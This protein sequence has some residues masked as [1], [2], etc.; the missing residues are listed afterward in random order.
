MLK[1]SSFV[2]RI[3]ICLD[4]ILL[5]TVIVATRFSEFQYNFF[6]HSIFVYVLINWLVWFVAA[7]AFGLYDD[8]RMKPISIEW[9]MF[10]KAFG[11]FTLVKSFI[12]FQVLEDFSFER[13]PFL[14]NSLLI[15]ILLPTVKLLI[16]ILFKKLRNSNNYARKVLIVGAG[17]NG[18]NFYENCVANHFYGYQLTGFLDDEKQPQ[19]NGEYLGK[20]EDIENVIANY[21]VDDIVVALPV[22]KEMQIRKIVAVGEREG[23][24]VRIV[25]DYT[26][27][28]GGKMHVDSLGSLSVIT[29]RSLPLDYLD[30]K[31]YKRIFD[32][33]FSV[34]GIVFLF[35]WLFPIIASIIKLTSKGPVLFKQ[36]RWGLNN[37]VI[38]CLK[39]RTMV[40]NC[41][42]VDENGNYL[43]AQKND[44]R[45]TRIGKFLRKTNLDELPQLFNVLFGSMSLVGPRPHPVPLN[46][47]SKD[48]IEKYMMRH[49]VKPGI[50]GWA[51]VHGYRGETR[52]RFTMKKRVKY[53]LWYIENW[54]FW[55]DLQII[56]QTLVNMIKGEKNAY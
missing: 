41:K 35:S 2:I 3:K 24:R 54:T 28:S 6:A 43:Q 5:T 30:N 12:F 29:L 26:T 40:A 53:D 47:S 19:L 39:F 22:T 9:V 15:F 44:P 11:I 25:P 45:V 13:Y 34:L 17:E 49:W 4:L 33:I 10:L 27:F 20:T 32:I 50:T 56:V 16:R 46:I 21:E 48:S 51:Q 42:N 8:L 37:K 52:D 1:E 23:K 31:F 7:R 38:T 36:D 55:L 18:M 14:L